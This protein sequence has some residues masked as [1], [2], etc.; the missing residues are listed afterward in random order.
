MANAPLRIYSGDISGS[1]VFEMLALQLF[2]LIALIGLGMLM[3]KKGMK[4]L[5]VQ[6][7]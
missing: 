1:A 3:Q 2:W 5:C 6:G 4:R 7:G